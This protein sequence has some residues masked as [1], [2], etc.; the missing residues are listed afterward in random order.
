MSS[1]SFSARRIATSTLTLLTEGVLRLGLTALVSFWIARALG[2]AQFGMLN[3]ASALMVIFLALG[4]L[5]LEVPAVWRLATQSTHQGAVLGTVLGLRVGASLVAC[6]LAAAAALLL[7]HEDP[8]ALA[9]CL[10]VALAILGYAPSVFDLWFKAH[11]EAGAPAL[12]RLATTLLS[13]AAKLACL[14]LDGGVI[15]LAWTVVL[16]AGLNSL[17]LWLAWRHASRGRL[18]DALAPDRRLASALLRDGAPYLGSQLTGMVAAKIDVLLLGY[19]CSHAQTGLYSVVQKLSEVACIVPVVLVDAAYPAL[20]RRMQADADPAHGQLLFD[21]A[22]AAAL[23]SA[24]GGSLLA[25]PL[26]GLVFGDTYAQAVP[27][28]QW[29]LWTCVAAALGAARHRWLA[30]QG[31][32]RHVPT[33]AAVGALLS[34]ALNLAL[35]PHWGAMGAVAT[36]LVAP[37]VAGCLTSFLIRDLRATGVM[38]ARALWPWARLL[39]TTRRSLLA[40]SPVPRP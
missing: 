23:L 15:A 37:L 5:G 20:A 17:L 36:A 3:V 2:P 39:D 11:V 21:L 26:I 14:A 22:A 30:T 38:Q 16:E 28:Q 34:V 4:G 24:L 33:I 29:H 7:R 1:V 18:S 31:L 25:G 10:I 9:V 32:Q 8:Q 6:A 13:S 19:L 40:Q 12:A 35:V 27:L